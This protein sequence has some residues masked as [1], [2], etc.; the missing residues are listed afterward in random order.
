MK[1]TPQKET[2]TGGKRLK[3]TALLAVLSIGVFS[4]LL[5]SS[6]KPAQAQGVT[7]DSGLNPFF[8]GDQVKK[9]IG[10][11]LVESAVLAVVNG[12]NY[13]AQQIAYSAAVALTSDCPGQFACWDSKA[14][15]DGF[16]QAWQGAI[17]EAVGS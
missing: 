16:K 13:F 10:D 12:V 14:F 1:T 2:L 4:S 17:G 7:F 3:A 9:S 6:P 8:V 11:V 15:S 5:L